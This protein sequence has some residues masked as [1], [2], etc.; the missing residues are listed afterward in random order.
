MKIYKLYQLLKMRKKMITELNDL[1]KKLQYN[2]STIKG[3]TKNYDA[4]LILEEIEALKIKLVILKKAIQANTLPVYDKIFT[5]EEYKDTIATLKATSTNDGL[6]ESR[7]Y[8]DNP[9][10]EYEA[11]IKYV[12]MDKKIKAIEFLIDKLQEEIDEHNYTTEVELPF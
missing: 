5:I 1:K 7:G 8:G 2:N 10:Q 3:A 6:V 4:N 12:D 9:P 11:T